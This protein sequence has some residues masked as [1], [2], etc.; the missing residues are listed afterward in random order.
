MVV[1]T[2]D[3][4]VAAG[5]VTQIVNAITVSVGLTNQAL[6]N[7]EIYAYIRLVRVEEIN[8]VET[9][10]TS[11]D[12]ARL[13]NTSDGYL[14]TIPTLR[15]A[16]AADVVTF[17]TETTDGVCG[18]AFLMSSSSASNPL[19]FAPLAYSIVARGC[20]QSG[21]TMAHEL[22]HNFGMAHDAANSA[23][24]IPLFNYAYG[25]QHPDG[26][27][28]TIMAYQNG[29]NGPCPQ[30]N[31]FSSATNLL[32]IVPMGSA[33]ANAE[34]VLNFS[35]PYVARFRNGTIATATPTYTAPAPIGTN[36]SN[37]PTP[38]ATTTPTCTASISP[39][40]TA[41]LIS[42]ITAA[43][44]NGVSQD[45]ICLANGST[46]NVS[47]PDNGYNGFPIITTPITIVGNNATLT[48]PTAQFY[49]FFEVGETGFL[50]ISRLTLQ[51][52]KADPGGAISV[53]YGGKIVISDSLFRNNVSGFGGAVFVVNRGTS[54]HIHRSVFTGNIASSGGGVYLTLTQN[55]DV[56]GIRDSVF[57]E[58]GADSLQAGSSVFASGSGTTVISNS[59][60]YRNTGYSVYRYS[61]DTTMTINATNNWWGASTGPVIETN[62]VAGAGVDMIDGN[63]NYLPYSYFMPTH[64]LA[65]INPPTA[66]P[67]PSPTTT[68]Q[69]S[70]IN[71]S[72][73]LQ[74]RNA[75]PNDALIVPLHIIIKPVS[76]GAII[77]DTTV[78]TNNQAIFTLIGLAEGS[79]TLWVKGT[80]TLATSQTVTIMPGIN[81]I[82]TPLLRE[83]DADNNNAI[84][85]PDF[86]LLAS[87]YGTAVGQANYNSQ[88]D[89]N[90]DG[91]VLLPDFSLLVSNF[92]M[93]GAGQP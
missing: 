17:I 15:N 45:V 22:G 42:A 70:V 79:Y 10:N 64:C 44:T 23:G 85:L 52:G 67:T 41:Q 46:Y 55:I 21:K 38:T 69:P 36:T 7:S 29:C 50:T 8:Y 9:G 66:T 81:S 40:N 43:N 33:S 11:T 49:R 82:S 74:G 62:P 18:R 75:A 73:T 76:G 26:I 31:R 60:L 89:F 68:P 80:H 25:Y 51:N 4:R 58:N 24:L 13:S 59:C 54:S 12:L 32:G 87:S 34:A 92:G 88:A 61:F 3:A 2:D 57:I 39:G 56:F 65:L 20:L 72:A 48:K 84:T 28:R 53:S 6:L 35:L 93:S 90:G 1:Y 19:N 77:V 37:A 47:I 91:Q 83:G 63:V 30:L 27:L 78:T 16:Y 5:G 14:D 86:S 71:V